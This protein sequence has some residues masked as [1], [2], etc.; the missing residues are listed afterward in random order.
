MQKETS[1]TTTALTAV[2]RA[3]LTAYQSIDKSGDEE[4][5]S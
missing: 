2:G 3:F 1:A 5:G 4:H